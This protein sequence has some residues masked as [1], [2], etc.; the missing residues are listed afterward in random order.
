MDELHLQIGAGAA[1]LLFSQT[2]TESSQ[3]ENCFTSF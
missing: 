2:L 3:L 1:P